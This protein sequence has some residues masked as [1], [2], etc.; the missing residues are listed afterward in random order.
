MGRLD[1]VL[2]RSPLETPNGASDQAPEEPGLWLDADPAAFR[3]AQAEGQRVL[4]RVLTADREQRRS[5][6]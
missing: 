3:P 5:P 4:I 1:A 6:I 2:G